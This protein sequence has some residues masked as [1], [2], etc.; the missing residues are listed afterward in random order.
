VRR[1]LARLEAE[2]I[3]IL[4]ETVA[5]AKNP[6]ML[7][8]AGEDST[9][10]AHLALR[11]FYPGKPPAASTSPADYRFLPLRE[12]V[13]EG[14]MRGTLVRWRGNSRAELNPVAAVGASA[15]RPTMQ[16]KQRQPGG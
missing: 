5:E 8:S 6:A 15:S 12:K 11:A 4:R 14:G 7:F 2:A 16:P 3:H 13:P 1:P 10:M 9:V